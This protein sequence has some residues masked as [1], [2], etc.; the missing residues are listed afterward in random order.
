[1]TLFWFYHLFSRS[2]SGFSSSPLPSSQPKRDRQV[3]TL[4]DKSTQVNRILLASMPE[5]I[6]IIDNR[7]I[8]VSDL[9]D[10]KHLK[11]ESTRKL[12]G[13]MKGA[14]RE[15]ICQSHRYYNTHNKGA[16][17]ADKD[18]RDAQNRKQCRENGWSRSI[19]EG[20][21]GKRDRDSF[22]SDSTSYNNMKEDFLCKEHKEESQ[23]K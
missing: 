4:H 14:I 23:T 5:S 16:S 3:D 22:F 11:Q 1:M 6:L 7:N 15:N 20:R 19:F 10:K 2:W 21:W 8:E 18:S 9:R 12:V 13:N 17:D